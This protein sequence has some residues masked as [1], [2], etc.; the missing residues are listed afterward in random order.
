[1]KGYLTFLLKYTIAIV[2]T[3]LAVV[4]VFA[5]SVAIVTA[6]YLLYHPGLSLA[7][8]LYITTPPV[9]FAL[10]MLVV[11]SL[12]LVPIFLEL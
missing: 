12:F 4:F 2:A 1:M 10:V 8:A 6:I 11:F 7:A 9:A 5:F 3:L